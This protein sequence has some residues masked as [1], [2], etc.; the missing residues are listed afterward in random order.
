MLLPK[1]HPVM[2]RLIP[3]KPRAERYLPPSL[4]RLQVKAALTETPLRLVL[5]TEPIVYNKTVEDK[6][7]VKTLHL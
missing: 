4:I 5:L 1:C 7:K 6:E 2:E 3:N